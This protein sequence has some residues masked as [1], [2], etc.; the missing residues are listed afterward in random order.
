MN[1][2]DLGYHD[3]HSTPLL[4]PVKDFQTQFS[5]TSIKTKALA[6]FGGFFSLFSPLISRILMKMFQNSLH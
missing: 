2:L 4:L 1:I 6:Q 5:E 3:Q